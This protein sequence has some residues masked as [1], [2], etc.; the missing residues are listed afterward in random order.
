MKQIQLF[1]FVLLFALQ[2]NAQFIRDK[3]GEVIPFSYSDKYRDIIRT[4]TIHSLVLPSFNNDSLFFTHNKVKTFKDVGSTFTYGFTIDSLV[5]FSDYAKRIEIEEGT[6]WLM[7]IES[8]TAQSIGIHIKKINIPDGVYFSVYPATIPG[9]MEDPSVGFGENIDVWTTKN[10]FERRI[11][12]RKIIVEFFAA[13]GLVYQPDIVISRIIYGF[14]GFGRPG[15]KMDYRKIKDEHDSESSGARLK[16]GGHTNTPALPCQRDVACLD[17]NEWANEA[18]SV[19]FIEIP[20]SYNGEEKL[21]QG[22]GFFLNKSGSGYADSDNPPLITCGHLLAPKVSSDTYCDISNNY[23]EI[24]VWVDYENQVCNELK[25]RYGKNIIDIFSSLNLLDLGSSYI[26]SS[27]TY[28][29]SEDYAIFSPSKTIKKLANY[30]IDYAG[31]NRDYD[32]L[33]NNNTGYAYIGHPRGDVKKVNIDNGRALVNTNGTEFGLYCDVGAIE[34]GFSGGPVFNSNSQV[35]GWV[36]TKG[37]GALNPCDEIGKDIWENRTGC[38]CLSNLWYSIANYVDP[39]FLYSAPSSNP[40]PPF[41]SELPSHCKDCVEN[42]DE[43]GIDCGGSCFPCGMLDIVTLKTDLEL[44]GK[45]RS[46]YEIFAEPDSGRLLALKSGSSSLEAGLNIYLSGRVEIEKGAEFY[47][48]IN[49]ELMTEPDRGCQPACV[50]MANVFT[51]N[52][53]GI[54]DYWGFNQS[55]VT[56]YDLLMLDRYGKTVYSTSNQPIYENGTVFAWDGEGTSNGQVYYG[57]LTYK[58]CYGDSHQENFFTHVYSLKSASISFDNSYDDIERIEPNKDDHGLEVYPN[59]FSD[60]ITIC[61]SGNL[62]LIKYRITDM[63]GKEI[64]ANSIMSNKEQIDLSDIS[65]GTYIISVKAEECNLVQKLI[66]M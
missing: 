58:D 51:P 30:N 6:L 45:V 27:G 10:G 61:Y 63:K 5:R 59:P 12:D 19:V 22:S 11:H 47:A 49:A 2:S 55:F 52:G 64:L 20:F 32:M 41:Y 26:R 3:R 42:E 50:S 36:C 60:K 56:S 38:G 9:I 25:I 28:N 18:K 46:R 35:V 14:H 40:Q 31:W 62:C 8:E 21:C 4:D 48:G 39:G 33:N 57:T 37:E 24:T 53:D 65:P 13:K 66:K 17:V 29:P 16:S 34:E 15:N 54:N 43:T 7:T 44:L 23:S 1:F